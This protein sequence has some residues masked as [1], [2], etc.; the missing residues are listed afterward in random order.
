MNFDLEVLR[1]GVGQESTAH[2]LRALSGF[3]AGGGLHV[4]VKEFTHMHLLD[5]SVVQRVQ[6]VLDGLSFRVQ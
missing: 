1:D 2:R 3:F 6:G 4:E 5:L